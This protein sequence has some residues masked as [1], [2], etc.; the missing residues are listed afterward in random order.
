MTF[1]LLFQ[2]PVILLLHYLVVRSELHRESMWNE[3][4]EGWSLDATAK[5]EGLDE[6]GSTEP[7]KARRYFQRGRF[8][9]FSFVLFWLLA[10]L[11]V[12]TLVR[13]DN[14]YRKAN[15]HFNKAE[16]LHD[17]QDWDAAIREYT[18]SIQYLPSA[19]S[20]VARGNC[21]ARKNAYDFAMQ[22][23]NAAMQADPTSFEAY[24]SRGHAYESQQKFDAAL[25]DYEK[26]VELY[27][28]PIAYFYRARLLNG[29]Y[30]RWPEARSS[31]EA[32][33]RLD[34][35]LAQAKTD[36]GVALVQHEEGL[37]Q[38]VEFLL[39]AAANNPQN[40]SYTGH[41][42][43][44]LYHAR[45]FQEAQWYLIQAIQYDEENFLFHEKL[46]DLR[47]TLDDSHTALREW[48]VA[49]KHAPSGAKSRLKEK[50]GISS[51][52]P[53]EA[54]LTPEPSVPGTSDEQA[55]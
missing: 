48:F 11:F 27:P 53:C 49:C 28:N 44:A 20:F 2:A 21:Y 23:F 29:H 39:P 31:F 50:L 45:R 19:A 42:G 8:V 13:N 3:P 37:L 55:P 33:L 36:F 40:S 10:G 38:A 34:N 47:A 7:P 24:T 30:G 46:G 51:D 43:I 41:L 1:S 9:F 12:P 32:A 17:S 15:A 52:Q 22:D 18:Q 5:P 35:E 14:A 26:S 6:P 4:D 16:L 25:K 54:A